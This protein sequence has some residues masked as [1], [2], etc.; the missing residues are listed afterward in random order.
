MDLESER[1][2]IPHVVLITRFVGVDERKQCK[3][4]SRCILDAN[5]FMM[6][7][8]PADRDGSQ[9]VVVKVGNPPHHH[10]RDNPQY[11]YGDR[12]TAIAVLGSAS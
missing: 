8:L 1:C 10:S 3:M 6:C 5:L 9:H 12:S 7:R 11:H 4:N 2:H